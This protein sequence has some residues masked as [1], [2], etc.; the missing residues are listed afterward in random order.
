MNLSSIKG[1]IQA[2]QQIG[3]VGITL[4]VREVAEMIAEEA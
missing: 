2:R 1:R 3:R 4:G